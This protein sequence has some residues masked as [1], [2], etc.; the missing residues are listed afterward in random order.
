M[1]N[2]QKG[3]S[4][5]EIMVASS[6]LAVIIFFSMNFI[7]NQQSSRNVRTNQSIYRYLAIQATQTMATGSAYYPPI[8]PSKVTE[9]IVYTGCYNGDGVLIQNAKGNREYQFMAVEG[10]DEGLTTNG[11]TESASYEVRFLWLN[12]ATKEV[13]INILSLKKGVQ[14]SRMA[15]QNFKIFAK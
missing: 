10:W 13:L 4:L 6:I 15:F 12:P 11:C 2:N 7:Q 9:T 5:V 8:S 14:G 1:L 3:F